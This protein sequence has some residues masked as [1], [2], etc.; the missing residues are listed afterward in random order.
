V[1]LLPHSRGGTKDGI[2]EH[3]LDPE[4]NDKIGYHG[5]DPG[6]AVEV[7]AGSI[8]AF[9]SYCL[10]RSGPNTVNQMRRVYLPQ[11]SSH[12][13]IKPDGKLRA[14][15]T[16]FVRNGQIVYDHKAEFAGEYPAHGGDPA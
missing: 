10:H 12:P 11:Y 7:P 9:D 1:Y 8:V 4:T 3:T 13:I 2:V 14:W 15:A 5:D 6:V 16:P